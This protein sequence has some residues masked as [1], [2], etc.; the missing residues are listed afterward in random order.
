MKYSQPP[1]WPDLSNGHLSEAV[2]EGGIVE[3][4]RLYDLLRHDLLFAG[5]EPAQKLVDGPHPLGYA[6]LQALP[7]GG[8]HD[9]GEPIGRVGLVPFADT[10]GVLLLQKKIVR[11]PEVLDPTFRAGLR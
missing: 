10:E 3:D 9:A 6:L 5:L 8:G 11:P 7:V 4:A 2:G 1:V